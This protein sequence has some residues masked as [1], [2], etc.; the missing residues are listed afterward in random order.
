[1]KQEYGSK[2]CIAFCA[3]KAFSA[4]LEEFKEFC[5][6][7]TGPYSVSQFIQFG[8][9]KGFVT[10]YN[11]I[12]NPIIKE[13]KIT[14]H[15]NISILPALVVVKSF[16]QKEKTHAIYWDGK[17]LHDSDPGREH[18]KLQDYT[19]LHWFPIFQLQS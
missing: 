17:K 14:Q 16:Y 2:D 4:S 12:E 1:M 3:Q 6:D 13:N 5:N 18:P 9:I 11:P 7:T 8:F 15:I 10:G 19:I